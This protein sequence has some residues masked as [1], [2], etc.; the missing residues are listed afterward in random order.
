MADPNFT[1]AYAL[2]AQLASTGIISTPATIAPLAF[3]NLT[4]ASTAVAV[5]AAAASLNGINIVN[6]EG[7]T[8]FVKFYNIAA[9]SV[10]PASDVPVLTLAVPANGAFYARGGTFA[11]AFSTAIAVRCTTGSG[12]TSTAVPTNKPIIEL[13]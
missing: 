8:I 4:V 2:L 5:A 6:L 12:D 3:R 13:D 11:K 7:S 9:A 1:N 10:N